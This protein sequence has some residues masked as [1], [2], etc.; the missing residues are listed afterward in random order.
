VWKVDY[1]QRPKWVRFY[2]WPSLKW[3]IWPLGDEH[4]YC[5][6]AVSRLK[7]LPKVRRLH[8]IARTIT[9]TLRPLGSSAIES[10]TEAKR[11]LGNILSDLNSAEKTDE[12]TSSSRLPQMVKINAVTNAHMYWFTQS[13]LVMRLNQ[14]WT[15][16]AM[17]VSIN[18][19]A[20]STFQL[21]VHMHRIFVTVPGIIS[22]LW[23]ATSADRSV[24]RRR[25]ILSS[26]QTQNVLSVPVEWWCQSRSEAPSGGRGRISTT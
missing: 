24:G 20:R 1:E 8:A 25:F 7:R 6:I 19:P 9:L 15:I 26:R 16:V 13:E 4:R 12:S 11:E 23:N 3:W 17:S 22:V 5:V 2:D 21:F 10:S 18:S 14:L